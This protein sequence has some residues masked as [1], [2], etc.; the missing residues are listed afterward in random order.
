VIQPL[1]GSAPVSIERGA[2]PEFEE[3]E[4]RAE[5]RREHAHAPMHHAVGHP[6][7]EYR[8]DPL[9]VP[10]YLAYPGQAGRLPG[11]TSDCREGRDGCEVYLPQHAAQ[12]RHMGCWNG[13]VMLVPIMIPVE[14]RAVVR[15]YVTEEWIEEEVIVGKSVTGT[16]AKPKRGKILPVKPRRDRSTHGR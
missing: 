3:L 16:A 13:P 6:P 2:E 15:E 7:L 1:P 10:V 11:E 14:Q 12:W 5:Y 8:G 4:R 9:G